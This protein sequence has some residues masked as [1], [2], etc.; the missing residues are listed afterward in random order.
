[1]A[2]VNSCETRENRGERDKA[3]KVA[4][5]KTSQKVPWGVGWGGGGLPV[6]RRGEGRHHDVPPVD[7]DDIGHGLQDVEVEVGVAGDGA[8]QARLEERGPLLLQDAGRAAAVVLADPGHPRKHHLTETHTH[9]HTE[10]SSAST[11]VASSEIRLRSF[12]Y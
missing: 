9:T 11:D 2:R 4:F 12:C 1:M 10:F 8:V 3:D 5:L 7:A 6:V